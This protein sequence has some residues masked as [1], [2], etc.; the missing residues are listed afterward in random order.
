MVPE[1][2]QRSL[3]FERGCQEGMGRSEMKEVPE[4]VAPSPER[5]FI[6]EMN[7]KHYLE[8][9]DL[10]WAIR[11]R[12]ILFEMDWTQLREKYDPA[13]RRPID[14][15]VLLGLI[16]YGMMRKQWSLRELEGLGRRDVGAWWI[17]GGLTPDHSTIGYFITRHQE[18][19]TGE[20]FEE[21]TRGLLK[22]LKIGVTDVAGD[23]TVIEAMSSRYRLL[24]EEALREEAS[25]ARE[26]AAKRPGDSRV[27]ER[28]QRL[29]EAEVEIRGRCERRE[30]K[31]RSTDTTVVSPVEPEAYVQP[32]K[33]KTNRPSYKPSVLANEARMIVGQHVSAS[34]ETDAIEP[35]LDQH[36][37]AVGGAV[38]RLL[39]D[40][41]YSNGVVFAA[42]LSGEIDLLCPEGKADC[43]EWEKQRSDGKYGKNAFRY[44]EDSGVYRCPAG[45]E[46]V[47][48]CRDR[49]GPGL[50][51]RRYRGR[52]CGDCPLKLQCTTSEKGRT[53]RRYEVDEYKEAM[54]EVLSQSG[55]KEKYRQR[56]AMVE[57]VFAELR[58]RQGLTRFRR[59][60]LRKVRVE[61][62][63]HCMAYNLKRALRLDAPKLLVVATARF[64][65]ES[66]RFLG[67]VAV[68]ALLTSF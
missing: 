16:F 11:L 37:R 31:G 28:A 55:A 9:N 66:S 45:K 13:G 38:K 39:L 63:L 50:E 60:G 34:N 44:E 51:Y 30:E 17:L 18:E 21:L 42:A 67:S 8:E 57:P 3:F 29:E 23:G 46:L 12:E 2:D 26:E 6:G 5:I 65:D 61:F 64:Y 68:G 47:Y 58:E 15:A 53:L 7:L 4:F 20:F 10:S 43:G 1:G 62:A 19:L 22:R 54:R 49:D 35:M 25:K 56:K 40:A 32:L 24:Q 36:E 48:E 33:N 59:R 14:P 27:Q 52:A 41:G